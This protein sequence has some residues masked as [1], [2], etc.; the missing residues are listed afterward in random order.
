[1]ALSGTLSH[2]ELLI[3]GGSWQAFLP[4]GT[5][6]Q[7]KIPIQLLS[8]PCET[9]R[10]SGDAVSQGADQMTW[11]TGSEAYC[12]SS[13]DTCG[14]VAGVIAGGYCCLM[15]EEPEECRCCSGAA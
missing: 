8:P 5:R 2:I 1:M 10:S 12:V 6:F 13:G 11:E 3:E 9:R 15:L 14:A 7:R 4:I